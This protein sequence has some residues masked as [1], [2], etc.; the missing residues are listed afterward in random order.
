MNGVCGGLSASVAVTWSC[1]VVLRWL[2]PAVF[3]AEV[4]ACI[5]V[6]VGRVAVEAVTAGC[7]WTACLVTDQWLPYR[8]PVGFLPRS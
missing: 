2:D 7:S 3:D 4:V 5:G 6:L 8:D 1:R